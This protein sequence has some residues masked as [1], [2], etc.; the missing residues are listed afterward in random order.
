MLENGDK[1]A[2]PCH[3]AAARA[4]HLASHHLLFDIRLYPLPFDL[5]PMDFMIHHDG[6][7]IVFGVGRSPRGGPCGAKAGSAR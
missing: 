7:D 2:L 6:R 4:I 3:R 5:R 1:A